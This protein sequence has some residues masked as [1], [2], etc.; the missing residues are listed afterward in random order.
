MMF[1][2]FDIGND[3]TMGNPLD[4][5]GIINQGFALASQAFNSFGGQTVGTQFATNGTHG[6][7]FALQPQAN[8]GGG[9]SQTNPYAGM[10]PEQ[11]AAYWSKNRPGGLDS[12]LDAAIKWIGN[13]PLII[14]GVGV[15][16]YLLMKEPPRSSA[17]R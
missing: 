15:G 14:V 10:S 6:G 11:I 16:A 8:Q 2:R 9:G 7:I 1:N 4:W 5:N 12:G 3:G 17:R 13:N